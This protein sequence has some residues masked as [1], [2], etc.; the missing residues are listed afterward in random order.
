MND[1]K[2]T[3]RLTD[4]S[5]TMVDAKAEIERLRD[6]LR[7][8]FSAGSAPP[9][10]VVTLRTELEHARAEIERLES[11][12][13]DEKRRH[14]KTDGRATNLRVEAFDLRRK[15]TALTDALEHARMSCDGRSAHSWKI[16]YECQRAEK[17]RIEA[18]NKSLRES[19]DQISADHASVSKQ[20]E[21]MHLRCGRLEGD[22]ARAEIEI[23][24]LLDVRCGGLPT[25]PPF[26]AY[27]GK[28]R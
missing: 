27:C 19:H 20:L 22:L 18:V 2:L 17:Y 11:E 24:N 4:A 16:R 7:P 10:H 5:L 28:E 8:D 12:L 1:K 9:Q 6:A 21:E 15:I 23:R 14:A 25:E 3:K 13:D 26:C